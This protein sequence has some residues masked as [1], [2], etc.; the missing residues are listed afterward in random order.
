MSAFIILFAI[1]GIVVGLFS[2]VFLSL[3]VISQFIVELKMMKETIKSGVE[4]KKEHLQEMNKLKKEAYEKKREAYKKMKD[5]KADYKKKVL[6]EKTELKF[7]QKSKK[8]KPAEE[9]DQNFGTDAVEAEIEETARE[10]KPVLENK[11]SENKRVVKEEIAVEI[12]SNAGK[13]DE[14]QA[15]EIESQA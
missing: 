1:L 15:I 9:T 4:L 13:V 2:L 3:S 5:L 8:D 7:R 14:E 10:S 11:A 12:N 6:L